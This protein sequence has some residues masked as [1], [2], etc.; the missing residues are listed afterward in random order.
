MYS[1]NRRPAR[2]NA[3][4]YKEVLSYPSL[5]RLCALSII[6]FIIGFRAYSDSIVTAHFPFFFAGGAAF[7]GFL[8]GDP[9]AF[10][11]PAGLCGEGSRISNS[12]HV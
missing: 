12:E 6:Y 8:A 5:L 2:Q 10:K 4:F 3:Q 1:Y 11:V 9:V 7:P